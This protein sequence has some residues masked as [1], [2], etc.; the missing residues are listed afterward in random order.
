[1]NW[2]PR[3]RDRE[4]RNEP[5]SSGHSDANDRK[6]RRSRELYGTRHEESEQKDPF[7]APD[8]PD[9]FTFRPK[10]GKES[11]SAA[12]M[13]RRVAFEQLFNPGGVVVQP[14]GSLEPVTGLDAV[15]PTPGGPAMP[16]LTGPKIEMAP[17]TA[18]NGFNV[19][20]DHLRLPLPDDF[21][22]RF[23]AGVKPAPAPVESH[24]QTSLMRQP[25]VHD[26]PA[27]KGL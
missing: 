11:L 12:Q 20:Q 23:S 5:F 13:E 10:D 16:M 24:F 17:N 19:Q 18:A 22:K 25:T 21:S 27:R 6:D 14:P 9:P 3:N 7:N 4:Q 15:K 26:I 8:A 1:V 2:D